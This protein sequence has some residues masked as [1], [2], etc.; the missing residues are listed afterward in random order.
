M[1]QF[2]VQWRDASQG[3]LEGEGVTFYDKSAV[4]SSGKQTGYIDNG[5][6]WVSARVLRKI[7]IL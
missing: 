5:F 7:R 3:N 4:L 2:D 1:R 6:D